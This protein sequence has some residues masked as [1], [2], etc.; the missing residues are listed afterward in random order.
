MAQPNIPFLKRERQGPDWVPQNDLELEFYRDKHRYKLAAWLLWLLLIQIVAFFLFYF[1]ASY[2]GWN[3]DVTSQFTSA[4]SIIFGPTS[5]L[6]GSAAGFYFGT[7]TGLAQAEDTRRPGAS[8][9][10]D[11]TS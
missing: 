1:V 4:I 2:L 6:V 7:R 11:P 10:A 3:S 5:A 8:G 9:G